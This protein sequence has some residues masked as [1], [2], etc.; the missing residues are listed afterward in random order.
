MYFGG[1]VEGEERVGGGG[2]GGGGGKGG[3]R[4]NAWE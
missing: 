1:R 2:G 3:V 4:D